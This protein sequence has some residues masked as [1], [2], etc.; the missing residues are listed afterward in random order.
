MLGPIFHNLV[1]VQP[2]CPKCKR[3]NT[4]DIIPEIPNQP[5]FQLHVEEF[6]EYT[7]SIG[8]AQYYCM[9]CN[10]KWKKYRGKK[11]YERIR[12][13][14]ADVGGYPGPYSQVKVDFAEKL[15]F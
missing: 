3:H 2:E 4:Y 14:N 12:A 1:N 15:Q 6:L 8:N 5:E 7:Y 10:D 9:D 13:I 11:P